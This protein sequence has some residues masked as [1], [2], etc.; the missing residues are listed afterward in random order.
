MALL[1]FSR[2]TVLYIDEDTTENNITEDLIR[3]V[4]PSTLKVNKKGKEKSSTSSGDTIK[5][6]STCS[7]EGEEEEEDTNS[8]GKKVR[9]RYSSYVPTPE[10]L[11]LAQSMGLPEGW[12]AK[13]NGK[14][15]YSFRSPDGQTRIEGKRAVF[16]YLGMDKPRNFY[17]RSSKN[18][19][20]QYKEPD[21]Y[22]DFVE[23]EDDDYKDD[24]GGEEKEDNEGDDD[25]T[26]YNQKASLKASK[27]PM[28]PTK[29]TTTAI[30]AAASTHDNRM[31]NKRIRAPKE[32]EFW[33]ET[34]GDDPPWRITGHEFIGK[35]IV[36]DSDID[37]LIV[38][39][40]AETDMDKHGQPGYV[41]ETDGKPAALF[42]VQF[43]NNGTVE[44]QD[45]EEY[46]ILNFLLQGKKSSRNGSDES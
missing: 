16:K 25:D 44:T 17:P 14:G 37:G 36:V 19:K 34:E 29:K 42:H 15:M 12:A 23:D 4:D 21:D 45:F 11:E 38:G 24:V 27:K 8:K 5:R 46:E 35:K 7:T 10:A 33:E 39:W 28:S 26:E 18:V 13:N 2:Y 40:I 43:D 6:K 20:I 3:K 32:D 1:F 30:S 22:D 41:S 9:K 31:V